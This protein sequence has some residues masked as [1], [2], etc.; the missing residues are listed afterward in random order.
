MPSK[1]LTRLISE[2]LL[3]AVLL[4]VAKVIGVLV[5]VKSFSIAWQLNTSSLL[6]DFVL[7]DKAA[8]VFVNSYSN[9]IVFVVVIIGLAWVLTKAYHF[10]DTHIKPSLIL[11]LLSWNLTGLMTS[12]HEVYNKGVVWISYMWL[13]V[14]LIGV[15]TFLQATYL[16]VF[17]F[18]LVASLVATWYFVADV[19]REVG[20]R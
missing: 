10:H 6:P 20:E 2:A 18:A 16:W 11:Q 13:V 8:T 15:H 5:L 1:I 14:L 17:V 9:L 19:E 3:P 7:H 4:V 12:S